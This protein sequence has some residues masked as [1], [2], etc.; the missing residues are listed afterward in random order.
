MGGRGPQR[1]ITKKPSPSPQ[2]KRVIA[3]VSQPNFCGPLERRGET[4]HSTSQS[5]SLGI[6]QWLNGQYHTHQSPSLLITGH[7]ITANC[8]TNERESTTTGLEWRN[9]M[10]NGIVARNCLEDAPDPSGPWLQ[11]ST[12]CS[13][14]YD[15]SPC[16]T[17]STIPFHN[18]SPV[19][20]DYNFYSMGGYTHWNVMKGICVLQSSCDSS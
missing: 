2:K 20:V 1:S 7:S 17:H 18:S 11:L 8:Y 12:D 19:I 9:G 6:Q 16:R 10:W 13:H 5:A 14:F 4:C 3:A 15:L